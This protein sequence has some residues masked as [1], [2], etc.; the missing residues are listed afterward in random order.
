MY[1][2]QLCSDS[3]HS[4]EVKLDISPHFESKH[5]FRN[6]VEKKPL[7]ANSVEECWLRGK[8]DGLHDSKRIYS[9]V[10]RRLIPTLNSIH[11]IDRGE[12]Y[13]EII[14]GH[15][16][17]RYIDTSINRF[18]SI[19]E[20][21]DRFEVSS[22]T[23]INAE[24][25]NLISFGTSHLTS[26]VNN[27]RWNLDFFT[28][29]VKHFFPEL[30]KLI[31]L[32]DQDDQSDQLNQVPQKAVRDTLLRRILS[33]G[34]EHLTPFSRALILS[35]YLP[36]IMEWALNV[37][38]SGFPQNGRLPFEF[39]R[40]KVDFEMREKFRLH[41]AKPGDTGVERVILGTLDKV[42][43][44]H[45]LEEFCEIV[46]IV[47]SSLLPRNPN[48]AF[49]S[50][51]FDSNDFFKIWVAEKTQTGTKYIVGQHG[52]NYGT[53]RFTT[54][55][56]EERTSDLFLTWGWKTESGN[57]FPLFNFKNP[58]GKQLTPNSLG[59]ILLTQLHFPNQ[60][61]YW[62][63]V[64]EFEDYFQS[65]VDFV[66]SL[67]PKLREEILLRLHPAHSH[68]RWNEENR[69]RK[70]FQNLNI[71][72]GVKEI[73][74]LLMDSR[75]VIHGYDST[76]LLETLQQNYPSLCFM[77]QG[78]S[79]LTSEAALDYATL[80]D[81]GIIFTSAVELA[82][83]LQ[84]I[85]SDVTSWWHSPE[86][87]KARTGFCNKYSRSSNQPFKDLSDCISKILRT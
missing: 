31:V 70:L 15:W 74:K 19:S 27:T 11:G 84:E 46:R 42:F 9:L 44:F 13:W 52:N 53:D 24:E 45:F 51:D 82:S 86:I 2:L 77:P 85:Y 62:D 87:Q 41:L 35:S 66:S 21:L 20:L 7:L 80:R 69:W 36:R 34:R 83:H 5:Y 67:P 73:H 48:F 33:K 30:A 10:L 23:T 57:Q 12:R 16:L 1:N 79:H 29:M 55:S 49:T 61:T 39:D 26:Q 18:N 58:H 54:G 81:A 63:S 8:E 6:S 59:G 4:D 68:F 43:P 64:S 71:E 76:G 47:Q 38:Y 72:N 60:Y 65:Q 3:H 75:I 17:Q 32:H 50:N 56:I 37:R 25:Y 22:V 40:Y 14:I 78:F 28:L